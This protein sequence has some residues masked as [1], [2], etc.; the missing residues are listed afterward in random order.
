MDRIVY[1]D[2]ERIVKRVVKVPVEKRVPVEVDKIVEVP[3]EVEKHVEV[4]V[5]RII[6]VRERPNSTSPLS[7]VVQV[8][9][10]VER[11]RTVEV[12]APPVV[13][14]HHVHPV[15]V[16]EHEHIHA[17]PHSHVHQH[18]AMRSTSPHQPHGMYGHPHTGGGF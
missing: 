17:H 18:A 3:V 12:P 11:I 6:K 5:E 2:K 15:H 14:T 4:P 10:T 9:R 13:H 1:R 16:H 8:P 7:C